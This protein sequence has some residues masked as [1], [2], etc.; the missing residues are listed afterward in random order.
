MFISS[1]KKTNMFFVQ[2]KSEWETCRLLHEMQTH[3]E[4]KLVK[5]NECH[6]HQI[7]EGEGSFVLNLK[8]L[9]C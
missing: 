5:L 4:V 2:Q 3:C 8:S 6:R 7:S 9:M 1:E